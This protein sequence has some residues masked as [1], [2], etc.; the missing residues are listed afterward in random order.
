MGRVNLIPDQD[1]ESRAMRRRAGGWF[2]AI[3]CV[4]PLVAVSLSLKYYQEGRAAAAIVETDQLGAAIEASRAVLGDLR[5]AVGHADG[6]RAR[7]LQMQDKRRW[8]ILIS[9]VVSAMPRGVWLTSLSSDP[10]VPAVARGSRRASNPQPVDGGYA[11]FEVEAARGLVLKGN[12]TDPS[13]PLRFV[14]ALKESGVFSSISHEHIRRGGGGDVDEIYQFE[15][16]CG[17]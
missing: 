13:S 4:L 3:C 7:A 15:I 1:Q 5:V 12:C 8:S 6:R 16:Q 2:A 9:K 10:S 14:T 11:S 17:W